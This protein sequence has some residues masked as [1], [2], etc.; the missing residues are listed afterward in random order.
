MKLHRTYNIYKLIFTVN[1]ASVSMNTPF[2]S[3]VLPFNANICS[4]LSGNSMYAVMS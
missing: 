1:I 4:I 3:N 2:V